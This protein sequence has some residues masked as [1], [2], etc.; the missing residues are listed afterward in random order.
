MNRTRLFYRG[1]GDDRQVIIEKDGETVAV[2]DSPAALVETH[3][4]G[5]LAKDSQ[6][7]RQVRD[8][9]NKYRLNDAISSDK[10]R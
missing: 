5:I 2:Y 1:E 3:I 7:T 6:D 9:I 8:I 10:T 4:K